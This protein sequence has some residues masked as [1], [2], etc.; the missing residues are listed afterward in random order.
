MDITGANAVVML[1][2]AI[3]FPVPQQLQG[4][5]T[6]DIYEFDEIESVETQMGVD[7]VLS[8]GFTFKP[9]PQSIMLQADS[10]S[11]DM[12]DIINA[13]QIATRQVYPLN[14]LV[15]I[16]SIGKKFLQTNG[17]LTGYKLPG[18]KKLVGPRRY[19]ITWNLVL[20]APV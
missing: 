20:P 17:F 7:G 3:L 12:F 1:S 18:V 5:A 14:G 15:S 19:R 11:N 9:Q 6:D 10:S 4:F 8:A 2:Q 13:Q 16:P